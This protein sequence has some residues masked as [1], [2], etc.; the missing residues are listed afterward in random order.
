MG[1]TPF[2]TNRPP[3]TQT[4]TNHPVIRSG[5]KWGLRLITVSLS[6]DILCAPTHHV[7]RTFPCLTPFDMDCPGCEKGHR[8]RWVGYFA[9]YLPSRKIFGAVEVTALATKTIAEWIQ[10]HGSLRNTIVTLDRLNSKPNGQ[11]TV[12][13]Q[14]NQN[15]PL[16]KVPP[17]FDLQECLSRMWGLHKYLAG[18]PALDDEEAAI[19]RQFAEA[20][21]KA[22]KNGSRFDTDGGAA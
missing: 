3:T 11:L 6:T 2:W 21:L 14:P 16:N 19:I 4:R 8:P 15:D 10:E 5:K 17:P 20:A 18:K 12:E 7:G 9:G 1:Q 13:L 22:R